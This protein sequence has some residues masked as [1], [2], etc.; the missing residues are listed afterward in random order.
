MEYLTTM[1]RKAELMRQY[2]SERPRHYAEQSRLSKRRL[3]IK[4]LDAFGRICVLC[5]F[6]DERALTLD[7]RLNN[8]AQERKALGE[9]GVYRRALEPENQGEYRMICMNCQF[10]ERHKSDRQNQHP[11]VVKLAWETLK[12]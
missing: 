11:A 8:G 12:P 7:H 4:V 3:R 2:R 5:G 6:S 1:T 9:R 10:I